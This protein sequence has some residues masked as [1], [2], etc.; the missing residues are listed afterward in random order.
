VAWFPA[1]GWAAPVYYEYGSG[2]NVVYENNVVYV[3]GK[4]VGTADEYAKSATALAS[5]TPPSNESQNDKDDWMPLGSFAVFTQSEAEHPT[6][7]LQLAVNKQ[8][9]LSGVFYNLAKDT[10]V[11]IHGSVDKTTQRAAFA[12]DE[13]GQ[14]IAEVGLSN[15]TKGN[16]S[17]LVHE[18]EGKTTVYHLNRLAAPPAAQE[19]TAV[20]KE[21]Q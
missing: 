11:A 1:W 3:D 19:A 17:L 9:V 8:G 16:A 12:L 5:V 20:Q 14:R 18:G 4:Q 7:T 10:A 2:G 15:L 13:K 6:A 21:G